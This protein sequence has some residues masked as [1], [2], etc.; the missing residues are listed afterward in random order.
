MGEVYSA[1][2]TQK[3]ERVAIK[4]LRTAA[5]TPSADDM[6]RFLR[7]GEALRLLAHPNIVQVLDMFREGDR[8]YLVMELV[9]GGSLEA[10]LAKAPLELGFILSLA[11]DLSDALA[12]AHRLGIVHRDIKPSN[13]LVAT[14]GTRSEAKT[15]THV[16]TSGR[17]A[18][19]C[20]R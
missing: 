3:H 5:S 10:L 6:E 18:C 9:E 16:R 14:D 1:F 19:S 11:L 2:D 17:S 13:V 15:P 20:S 12:R 8:H 7:E 4:L